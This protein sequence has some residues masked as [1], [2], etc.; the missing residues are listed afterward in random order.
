M[1]PD[2]IIDTTKPRM[3]DNTTDSQT[4]VDP[5]EWARTSLLF[6]LCAVT[7]GVSFVGYAVGGSLIAQKLACITFGGGI[8][9]GGGR[10][11]ADLWERRK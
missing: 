8:V 1:R 6:W 2:I 10:K 4:R 3:P 11:L 9:I 5:D 7:V